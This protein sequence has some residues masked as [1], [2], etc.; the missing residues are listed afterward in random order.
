MNQ[1]TS[2]SREGNY[3]PSVPNRVLHMDNIPK[4][5]FQQK[6]GNSEV[7][8]FS[9]KAEANLAK[10]ALKVKEGT[11]DAHT[12]S[13]VTNI[14]NAIKHQT[15]ELEEF[16]KKNLKDSTQFTSKDFIKLRESLTNRAEKILENATTLLSNGITTV[17]SQQVIQQLEKIK[18]DNI[19]YVAFFRHLKANAEAQGKRVNFRELVGV[20]Y[21]ATPAS[22]LEFD[23]LRVKEMVEIY[24]KNYSEPAYNK[25]F[26]DYLVDNLFPGIYPTD[27]NAMYDSFYFIEK[28][29]QIIS[30]AR[31]LNNT[32]IDQEGKLHVDSIHFG[33]FNTNPD[34]SGGLIG[35]E[36]LR[37]ALSDESALGVPIIAE[38]D[39]RTFISEKY[40]EM[41]FTATGEFEFKGVKS[42]NILLESGHLIDSPE[43]IKER[44][45]SKADIISKSINQAQ[46]E[47][48]LIKTCQKEKIPDFSLLK[49]G[50][51]LTRYFTNG[52]LRYC[53]FEKKVE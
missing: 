14:C 1:Q 53:L 37:Q 19:A 43:K 16:V 11:L 5:T 42:L 49:V 47:G 30:F 15:L 29:N 4:G 24:K 13:V 26:R 33:A 38:C 28:E 51:R 21:N 34:F 45:I 50:Y 27:Y 44:E 17:E 40:I 52:N 12:F 36:M 46:G 7:V 18:T 23:G 39:P 2:S 41:G 10:L 8:G 48:Y 35:D 20:W 22:E 31:F 25:E 9:K 6:A 32:R 3:L